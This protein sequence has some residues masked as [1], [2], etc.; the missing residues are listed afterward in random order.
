MASWEPVDINPINHGEIGEEDYK[1]D[2]DLMNDLGRDL[3][4]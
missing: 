1:W 4:S 2:D 3:K